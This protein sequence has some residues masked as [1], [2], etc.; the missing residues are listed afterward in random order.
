MP[1]VKVFAVYIEGFKPGDG[2]LTAE[3]AARILKNPGR[4]IIVYKS[5]RTPEGRQA[6]SGHTASVAGDYA[7]SLAILEAAGCIVADT[8][9]DFDN[10]IK[11]TAGLAAKA[12]R[13]NRVALLSNAGFES[14]VMA[15]NIRD[16][17]SLSLAPFAE[18]TKAALSKILTPL[19]IDKLQDVK[20]PLDITP[21]ADDAAFAACAAALLEDPNV[22]CAVIS[23][24]PMTPA[25]KTLAP[26]PGY[27]ESIY[28][29]AS[30]SSRLI[31]LFRSADKPFVVNIDAG[32]LY[33]PMVD[34]L[35]GAGVPV[36]RQADEAVRFLR[37]FVAERLRRAV[38]S[39]RKRI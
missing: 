9:E 23:P 12:V 24:V 28:D 18:G 31:A 39:P 27:A 14:V 13:G 37:A 30:V 4:H 34:Q 8:I 2:H 6:T 11:S 17:D 3:A 1:E 5:G 38:L 21:V 15:D 29:P 20:N 26:G 10:L 7:V 32:T 16:G 25:L 19:G 33:D 35:E 22:D 36:F